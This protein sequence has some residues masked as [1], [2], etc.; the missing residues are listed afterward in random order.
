MRSIR[1]VAAALALTA[2][3]PL[4]LAGCGGAANTTA[5][6]P[7]ATVTVTPQP[8]AL[9]VGF[10]G[11]AREIAAYQ[12]AIDN[13]DAANQR[14]T[15][16]L[17]T[18]RN[19][20]L[21][22]RDLAGGTPAP[23]IFLAERGDLDV[24]QGS[25]LTQ[26]LDDLLA[27][28]NVDLGDGYSRE[29]LEA[30]SA[31]HHLTCMPYAATPQVLFYNTD[32]VDFDAMK[33]QGQPVPGDLTSGKWNLAQFDA[34][35]HWAARPA[36]GIR[37]FVQ[38][39]DITGL[40]PYLY[41]GGGKVVDD[42]GSPT[43]L[44]LSDDS[45][46]GVWDKVLPVLSDA[47]T[48][49]TGRQLRGHSALQWFRRG[50]L[51]MLVGDR[52]MVPALRDQVGLHWDVIGLPAVGE[53]ATVGDYTGLCMSAQSKDPQAAAD[54][55]AYLISRPAVSLVAH[56]GYI[57]PA[58]AEVAMSEDFL[59]PYQRP[60]HAQVFVNASRAMHILPIGSTYLE[61]IDRQTDGLIA[62]LFRPGADTASLTQQIDAASQ[63][64]LAAQ[65]GVLHPSPTATPT[66]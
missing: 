64:V 23:D 57:V 42:D 7:T 65:N 49:V 56:A 31:D 12:A 47:E 51:A 20:A 58:S 44:A 11:T 63:P 46:Q 17:K 41:S 25:K 36:Q 19:A 54:L 14:V 5:P 32:L 34:A 1:A 27:A 29:A 38:P 16:T 43:S 52:S 53:Q 6:R 48:A 9:T 66:N 62:N 37:A 21:M 4:V 28:R 24:L 10:F 8:V 35:A 59:Q 45:N 2:A 50:R 13:Y 61:E 3:V 55:L 15:L 39:T 26:P 60:A 30:F 33:A 18:W 40:A 22:M